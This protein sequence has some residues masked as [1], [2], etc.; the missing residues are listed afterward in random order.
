MFYKI[1][2]CFLF[3]LLRCTGRVRIQGKEN[4]PATGP[5]FIIANHV[6][7]FDPIILFLITKR[8]INFMAKKE[9]FRIPVFSSVVKG[10]K[11]FPVERE[12][13]DRAAIRNAIRIME[14]GELLG[15]FPEG[16]RGDGKTL[17]PFKSGAAYIAS[18]VEAPV[19]PVAIIG[20]RF[21]LNP[22]KKAVKVIIGTEIRR[23]ASMRESRR[24]ALDNFLQCQ[25]DA[26]QS[27][28]ENN[29]E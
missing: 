29:V 3:L 19:I 22:F 21:L 8:P 15:V 17:L 6:S 11:A 16:T 26:V 10:M 18:Q 4:I 14:N 27:L 12:K 9:L 5:A 24:E 28:L 2:S 25:E 7:A 20:S 13:L 23:N 1:I